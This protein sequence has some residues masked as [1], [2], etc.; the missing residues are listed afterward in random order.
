VEGGI[1]LPEG[2][3]YDIMKLLTRQELSSQMLAETLGVSPTAVRQ[4]LETLEALGLV[5]RRKQVSQPNR[6]TYLYRLSARGEESFPK[7]Y[8]LLLSLLVEVL[9]ERA[10]DE[11]VAEVIEAAAA[12]LAARVRSRFESIDASRRWSLLVDWLEEELAWHADV[13]IEDGGGRRIT[14]HQCPFQE[15]SRRQPA[16]CGVFFRTLVRALYGPVDVVHAPVSGLACCTL[17]VT[18]DVP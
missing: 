6:P 8:D 11:A 17:L 5:M 14:I 3:K 2:T 18:G 15:V 9:T 13:T 1:R 16:V 7:R 4:H 12:R 10:G